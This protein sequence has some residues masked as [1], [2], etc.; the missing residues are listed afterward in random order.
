MLAPW[1]GM[2]RN[3]E[4]EEFFLH[5]SLAESFYSEQIILADLQGLV[6]ISHSLMILIVFKNQAMKA[7][8][9]SRLYCPLE[10]LNSSK[11]LPVEKG[12]YRVTRDVLPIQCT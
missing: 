7:G 4:S 10:G 9:S 5:K 6:F 8:C 12:S 2:P 3:P 1:L 11:E